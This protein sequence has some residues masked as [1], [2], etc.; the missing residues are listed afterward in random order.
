MLESVK[1]S[2]FTYTRLTPEEIKERGILG[3]LYG[4]IA[5]TK[6]QTQS[7]FT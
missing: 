4:P 1:G 2:K 6:K 5:D 3:T 7:L